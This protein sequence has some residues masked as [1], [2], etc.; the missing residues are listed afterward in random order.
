MNRTSQQILPLNLDS[1]KGNP[2]PAGQATPAGN[3][4]FA[5]DM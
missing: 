5:L 2:A 4:E 3:R 1:A